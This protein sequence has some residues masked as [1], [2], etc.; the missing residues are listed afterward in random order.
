[1]LCSKECSAYVIYIYGVRA[2]ATGL[3]STNCSAKSVHKAAI[4]VKIIDSVVIFELNS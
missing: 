1:M 4:F 2:V 3:L